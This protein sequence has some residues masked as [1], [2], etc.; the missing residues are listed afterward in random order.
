MR[1]PK[2]NY[3]FSEELKTCPRCGAD[4][5]AEIEKLGV[6]P[7]SAEEPFL[8]SEDFVETPS[9]IEAS[10]QERVIDFPFSESES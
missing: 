8:T 3:F 4:M 1:C 9:F 6:F 2:C 10:N 7:P 5:G